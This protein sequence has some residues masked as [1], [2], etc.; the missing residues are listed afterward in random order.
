ML[1]WDLKK[2]IRSVQVLFPWLP[3]A[4]FTAHY[5]RYKYSGQLF[6]SEYRGLTC[7]AWDRPLLID[8]GANRGQSVVAFQNAIPRCRV[9]AFEPIP[10]L[11]RTLL[12]RYRDDPD[13]QVETCA[14]AS[15]A[16]VLRLFI[17]SYRGFWFDG[18]A[19]IHREEAEGWLNSERLYWFDKRQL[20]IE[21]IDVPTR[22]LDS[23]QLA[24]ALLKLNVERA[25][26]EVLKGA[27]LTLQRHR[28]AILSAFPW[29]AL[30]RMLAEFGYRPHSYENGRFTSDRLGRRF[31]WF[32]LP[33][34]TDTLG[35]RV[36]APARL[37]THS[38]L[39]TP[40]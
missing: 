40:T 28:P 8:I 15:K 9:L 16:G 1:R 25:E 18:L 32:L 12:N 10:K 13:V 29:D 20:T 36:D 19:S 26:I 4:K 35:A 23:F 30:I 22:T 37:G 39:A 7:F 33:E 24:P 14:L 27:T 11:A 3:D 21:E 17:P 38:A 2:A 31:T 5:W 34:H 6:E